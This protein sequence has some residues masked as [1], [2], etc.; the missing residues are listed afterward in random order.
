MPESPTFPA[1]PIRIIIPTAS[2][3]SKKFQTCL[4]HINNAYLPEGSIVTAVISSGSGFSFA[5]SINVGFEMVKEEDILLLNDDCFIDPNS[6]KNL[7][8]TLTQKDGVVGGVLRY[9]DGRIQHFG[10]ALK[11]DF[12]SIFLS[13]TKKAAPFYSIRSYRMAKK[14]GIRYLRTFH[15]SKEP[16]RPIDYVTGAFFFIKNKVFQEVGLMDEKLVNDWEDLDY[17]LRVKK[18]GYEIRVEKSATAIHQEHASLKDVKS[19]FFEKL[20]VFSDKW[21]PKELSEVLKE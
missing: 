19:D 12:L 2:M 8:N 4:K 1:N 7:V 14:E 13:D 16:H 6:I 21:D 20:R 5:K 15:Y 3:D 18:V 10:G 9:E 11:T 17:C